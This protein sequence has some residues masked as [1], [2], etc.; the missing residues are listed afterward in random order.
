MQGTLVLLDGVA[1]LFLLWMIRSA[2]GV[3]DNRLRRA[4]RL[5]AATACGWAGLDAAAILGW[6][7]GSLFF[8]GSSL[9]AFGLGAFGLLVR[10][11]SVT[12]S[13]SAEKTNPVLPIVLLAVLL[14]LC[15]SAE[16]LAAAQ[17]IPILG[18]GLPPLLGILLG[19]LLPLAGALLPLFVFPSTE[20]GRIHHLHSTT[21]RIAAGSVVLVFF[22][23]CA[24]T[25]LDLGPGE[26]WLAG[27]HVRRPPWG[28]VVALPVTACAFVTVRHP[29]FNLAR[30]SRRVLYYVA[31]SLA[32]SVPAFLAL[33]VHL[34]AHHQ[35]HLP[36]TFLYLLGTVTTALVALVLTMHFRYLRPLAPYIFLRDAFE[37]ER[38]LFSF[39]SEV[40]SLEEARESPEAILEI[41]LQKIYRIFE[42][43]R[44]LIMSAIGR[45]RR[46]YRFIGPPPTFTARGESTHRPFRLLRLRLSDDFARE[47]D[48]VFLLEPGFPRPFEG[49]AHHHNRTA[50]QFRMAVEELQREGYRLILP[51]IFR[52]SFVG[53]IV[54]GRKADGTPYYN[55]EIRMLDAARLPFAMAVQ[56]NALLDTFRGGPPEP[57]LA[58]P[59]LSLERIEPIRVRIGTDRTL[60]YR[61][62]AVESVVDRTRRVAGLPLPVL[63]QGETGTGK[64]LIARLLHDE[65]PGQA[66]PFVAVNC[67]AIPESLWESEL[68]GHVRGTFTDARTDREGLVT[69]ARNG[70]LFFDEIGEMPP[71]VQP[72]ILRLI[73]ERRYVPL[74]ARKELTA[75]CKLVF[76]THRDLTAMVREG[77][78]REDLYY[79]ISTSRLLLPALRE[80]PED[81]EP[82]V[83]QLLARFATELG[84][85]ERSIS[86]EAMEALVRYPW[87]GNVRELENTLVSVLMATDRTVVTLGDLPPELRASPRTAQ[88]ASASGKV[89]TPLLV[90]ERLRAVGFEELV[91]NY[92][93]ELIRHALEVCRGNRTHAA[94]L[95]QISRGKLIYRLRELGLE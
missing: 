56:H 53:L 41:L 58:A 10:T 12:P 88:A 33:R 84:A 68:F 40:Q 89:G 51:L 28:L 25:A 93:R 87:P 35:V 50:A 73:Q 82:L 43:E 85:P 61:S 14:L 13:P 94:R 66:E 49:G 4:F 65:G 46:L 34:A 72:K 16:Y 15:G 79:R 67:A 57:V 32:A 69:A 54:L 24:A 1:V 37:K 76:A 17:A 20:S 38:E 44:A 78:F 92:S 70:T 62:R 8:P 36:I 3:A 22:F 47:L 71:S 60:V 7:P 31:V 21:A 26:S 19:L 48:Q 45:G 42:C 30:I 52:R 18:S 83:I 27:L 29:L 55:G 2:A 77:R 80:R 63:V 86:A 81:I 59:A 6:L 95:L 39:V 75:G 91:T 11:S 23:V 9:F 64:E 74:G 90:E 5:Q